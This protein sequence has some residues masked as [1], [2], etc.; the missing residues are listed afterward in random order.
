MPES[1]ARKTEEELARELN[2]KL[3]DDL[4]TR[5]ARHALLAALLVALSAIVAFTGLG[6]IFL[7]TL[8]LG[9]IFLAQAVDANGHLQ[10]VRRRSR[11]RL[12][13]DFSVLR[14]PEGGSATKAQSLQ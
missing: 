6:M 9:L 12:V 8:V 4:V 10:E 3:E 1:V 13:P 7:A 2:A 11:K 14:R 5:R